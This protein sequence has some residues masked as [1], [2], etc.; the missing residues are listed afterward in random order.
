[1]SSVIDPELHRRNFR[2]VFALG[3]LF[4]LPLVGLNPFAWIIA[5]P[6]QIM[7]GWLLHLVGVM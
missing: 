3:G 5:L 6:A 4:L 2:T 1:M 7:Q